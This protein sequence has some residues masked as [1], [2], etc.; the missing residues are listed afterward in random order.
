M[1]K[2]GGSQKQIPDQIVA[3]KQK[4]IFFEGHFFR[5]FVR[6]AKKQFFAIL[7]CFKAVSQPKFKCPA[8]S[9]IPHLSHSRTK[10][11]LPDFQ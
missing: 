4:I 8:T 11:G 6:T 3:D 5:F 1:G 9:P 7:H 2:D 10:A